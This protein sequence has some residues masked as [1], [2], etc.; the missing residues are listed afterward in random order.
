VGATGAAGPTGATGAAGTAGV[1]T[2]LSTSNVGNGHCLNFMTAGEGSCST[3]AINADVALAPAG[4]ATIANLFAV[5]SNAPAATQS[6]T[7][8]VTDNGTAVYSC[9]ITAGNTTCSNTA[10]SV[11]VTAGH[12]IQV[13]ISYVGASPN[14]QFQVSFRW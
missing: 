10:A 5:A 14:K 7:V 6:Y 2:Y 1:A 3:T 9:T 8:D 13:Q 4:G 11:A 12:R